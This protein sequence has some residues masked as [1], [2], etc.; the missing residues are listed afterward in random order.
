MTSS[1]SLLSAFALTIALTF[2]G[3][4]CARSHDRDNN[5]PGPAGGPGTNWENPPG[6]R[7]GPGASPGYPYYPHG[8]AR[9]KIAI[10]DGG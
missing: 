10:V 7:G 2:A 8:K 3:T 1:R 6:W 4:A 5:P 9:Y